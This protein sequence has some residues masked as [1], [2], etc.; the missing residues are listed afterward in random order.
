MKSKQEN[1]FLERS[2]F[3]R[4]LCRQELSNET[5]ASNGVVI[6]G[7]LLVGSSGTVAFLCRGNIQDYFF[8]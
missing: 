6:T 8:Q 2:L 1:E 3:Q 5:D 4:K 7:L